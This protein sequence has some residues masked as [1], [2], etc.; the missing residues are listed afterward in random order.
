MPRIEFPAHEPLTQGMIFSCGV[1]EDYLDCVTH[2]MIITAR[3]DAFNDKA[4]IYN[5]VPVVR[6]EDWLLQDGAM[7]VAHRA[8][9]AALGEMK[10]ALSAADEAV[11]LLDY[12]TPDEIFRSVFGA[13]EAGMGKQFRRAMD[14][15]GRC[16]RLDSG[17]L[18]DRTSF[19]GSER[20][21]AKKLLKELLANG[22]AEFHY[23][24][25]IEPSGD[26]GGYVILLRE[27]RHLPRSLAKAVAEGVDHAAYERLCGANI[28]HVGRLGLNQD[29][30]AWPVGILTSPD[31]E[32]VLQRLTLLFS[33]VGVSDLP[34][35]TLKYLVSKLP[36][37]G[38]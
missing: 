34:P 3:C 35:T 5:Y 2:G 21:E 32:L 9:R 25:Q 30:V 36:Q 13:S 20:A 4:Q 6:F 12:F 19:L 16:T 14:R 27:I 31:I 7:I 17:P 15:Y 33:R 37:S 29:S 38:K 28:S 22:L 8:L 23:L 24:P 11:T 26:Q 1:A 18:P 10:S